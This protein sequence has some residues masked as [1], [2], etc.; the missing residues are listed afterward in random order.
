MLVG[1]AVNERIAGAGALTVTLALAVALPPEPVA[2][3]VYVVVAV[4]LTL[5]LPF[6]H[7]TAPTPLSIEQLVAFVM[8]LQEREDDCPLV[9]PAGFAVN[10]PMAGAAGALTVTVVVAVVLPPDP[11]AVSV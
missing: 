2:V 1:F 6:A 4:G 5:L 8:P 10:E 3:S 7:D 11:V 9:M